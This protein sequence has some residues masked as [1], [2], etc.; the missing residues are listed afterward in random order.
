MFNKL[1]QWMAL[2]ETA[3]KHSENAMAALRAIDMKD[4]VVNWQLLRIARRE[5]DI[6]DFVLTVSE[7]KAFDIDVEE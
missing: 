6:S 7:S 5:G 1:A 2:Q 4:K 3:D